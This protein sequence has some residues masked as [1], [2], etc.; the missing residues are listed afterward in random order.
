[1]EARSE[2]M[3]AYSGAMEAHSGM[4]LTHSEAAEAHSGVFVA[5]HSR[6]E[7]STIDW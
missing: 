1:M 5:L 3:V 2:A 7:G 4:M 6:G